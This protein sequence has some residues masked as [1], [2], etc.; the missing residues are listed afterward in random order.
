MIASR[1]RFLSSIAEVDAVDWNALVETTRP[2]SV[3]PFLRHEFLTALEESG[4]VTARTGW[5]PKHLLVEDSHGRALGAM[6]LFRK[7]HSRGEFVFDFSWA[8]AYAQ[9]GLKY[10]PK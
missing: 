10:Y 1:A 4:C 3:Q 8:S 7:A 2:G 9:H 5:A 6:P